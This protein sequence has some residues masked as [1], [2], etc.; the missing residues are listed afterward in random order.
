LYEQKPYADERLAELAV[1]GFQV[2]MDVRTKI[3]VEPACIDSQQ[4]VDRGL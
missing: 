2:R 3:K 4:F 1:L